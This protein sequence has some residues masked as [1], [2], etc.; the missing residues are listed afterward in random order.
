[1]GLIRIIARLDIKGP[2][3][4]KGVHLEGLRVMG[5]P[6]EFARQYYDDGIDELIYMDT[7]ASLYRRNNLTEIVEKA[8]KN[9]F[10]PMT[11][12]GGM[13]SIE[14]A[15]TILRAGA[16]KVAIN[17]AAVNRPDFISEMAE[18]FGAQCMVLSI[19]AKCRKNGGWEVFTDNG[20]EHTGLDVVEWA[21]EGVA[22]GAGEIL[23]T[24]VDQEGT[25]KGFDSD[26]L[27]AISN[28]VTVPVIACGGMGRASDFV[29]AVK[30]GHVD[31]IAMASVLHKGK[32]TVPEIRKQV[33]NA[34]VP[35]R[36]VHY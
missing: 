7:V 34:G 29:N 20:R 15:R 8:T 28:S 11:V 18:C 3:L 10:V 33:L 12:G 2:N 9:V 22:L 16:D 21:K 14:D 1:M 31:A 27:S 24:S 32:L 36:P 17:T 30:L 6:E 25:E 26:L 23:L 4:I 19:E 5:D 35:V 13:R